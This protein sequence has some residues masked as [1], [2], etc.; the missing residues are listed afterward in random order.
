[1]TKTS[2]LGEVISPER[3]QTRSTHQTPR[4]NEKSCSTWAPFLAISL[5]RATLA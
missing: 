2:R 4:L 5:R 3:D 1:M